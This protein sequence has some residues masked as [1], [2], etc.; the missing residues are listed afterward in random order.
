MSAPS[1]FKEPANLRTLGNYLRGSNGVKS[2]NATQ[3]NKRVDY[4]R[5][6]RLL[7][8][9]V[10]EDE[11]DS[12]P[13]W[14]KT[15][16]TITDRAVGIAVA[17]LLIQNNYFHRS[18]KV[19]DKK[20]VL[21]IS[22]VNVFEENGYYTWMHEGSKT[23]ANLGTM[24]LIA[25]VVGFTLL[26]IWPLIAKKILWYISVTML[27]VIIGFCSIR[28]ALFMSVWI[29]GYEFWVF[30]NIF[31]E[32]MSF[33]DSFTPFI[34]FE[35]SA[36]G[37]GYYRFSLVAGLVAFIAWVMTQPTEFDDFLQGQKS[38]LDDLYSGNL[39][40]DVASDHKQNLDKVRSVPKFED[41]LREDFFGSGEGSR[42]NEAASGEEAGSGVDAEMDI[43]ATLNSEFDED[44][45]M[46]AMLEEL[47]RL[48]E[49]EEAAE[50][51][52][53]AAAEAEEKLE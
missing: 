30:P 26:P 45:D 49:E 48:E 50:L 40:A 15:L 9:L 36:D 32:S 6:G 44:A 17:E 22:K 29:F 33:Y 42:T 35:K 18:E 21:M 13:K 31:D 47:T 16:P 28:F 34:S 12:L 2:K 19:A 20:K 1:E 5:G 3:H 41:L 7:E 38:F 24:A 51:A 25:I 8:C 27:L 43:E 53:A 11:D 52:A 14:P 4:F 39:L 10:Q 23:W 37:Q 46:E